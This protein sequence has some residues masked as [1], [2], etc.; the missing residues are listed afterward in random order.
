M[1][2]EQIIAS[3]TADSATPLGN[4]DL[5][6]L[7][8]AWVNERGAPELLPYPSKVMGRV[9]KRL[10][11]QIETVEEE[12]GNPDPKANFRLIIIQTELERLKYLVRALLVA[13]IAKV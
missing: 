5:Q 8:R 12:T 11:Q 7:T 1:D 10:R 4:L 6:E 9:L 2:I 3:A 13:R